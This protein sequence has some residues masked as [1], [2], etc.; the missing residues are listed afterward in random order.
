MTSHHAGEPRRRG[1]PPKPKSDEPK[2]PRGRPPKPKPEERQEPESIIDD[3]HLHKKRRAALTPDADTLQVI[4]ECARLAC[5]QVECAA[6]L[7]VTVAALS[8]LFHSHPEAREAWDD[9]MSVAKVKLRSMQFKLAEKNQIMAIFL[10]KNML[11]QKDVQNIDATVSKP[12]NEMSEEQLL[13]I[14]ASAGVTTPS[15]PT[16]K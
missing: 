9:G 5:S 11:G 16:T 10:G 7:G 14:L 1:R 4:G 15:N 3:I 8:H 6:V 12:A 2:R 13:A